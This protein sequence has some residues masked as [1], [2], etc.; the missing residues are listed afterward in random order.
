MGMEVVADVIKWRNQFNIISNR[1]KDIYF[2]PEYYSLYE[3]NGDGEAK[4]ALY[5][6]SNGMIVLYPFILKKIEGYNLDR[7]YY[8][9]ESAYGYGGP[10]VENYNEKNMLEF[11][12]IFHNW[13]LNN[14]VVAEFIRFHPLMDNYKFFNKNIIVEKD[15]NTVYI[16]LTKG[17]E[18]IWRDSISSKNRNMIRKAEKAGVQIKISNDFSNFIDLYNSTMNRVGA[19][20]YYFFN[21]EYYKEM[22]S[23]MSS[24]LFLLE[25]SLENKIIAAAVFL[26]QGEYLNYHLSGSNIDYLEYA[27]NNLL[28]YEAIKIGCRKGLKKFHLGG[29]RS[30]DED[31]RLLHFKTSF[32]KDRAEFYIGKR[33]H[34]PEKYSY[35]MEQWEK[36][37]KQQAKLF[38]QYET[39]GK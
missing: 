9:I 4:A 25:A 10:I 33:I 20:Q 23:S 18:S 22:S 27:P 30:K 29:G 17:I 35:L 6:G 28:L 16:D 7:N 21:Q 12:E 24:N 32:S 14:N 11:E 8:D 38:L 36:E 5:K 15:R 34:N 37:N 39:R 3:I 31:D 13:C 26:Y 19:G 1:N 2:T